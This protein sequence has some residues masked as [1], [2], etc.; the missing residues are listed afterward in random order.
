MTRTVQTSDNNP[1]LPS[2]HRAC[3]VHRSWRL[4]VL[5]LKVRQAIIHLQSNQWLR[6]GNNSDVILVTVLVNSSIFVYFLK[7]D[8]FRSVIFRV[9]KSE[10][11]FLT[12]GC[13]SGPVWH[14]FLGI[15]GLKLHKN[16]WVYL[17]LV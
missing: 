16:Q 1:T 5:Q 7:S 8:Y 13:C 6:S 17:H 14:L 11:F 10:V 9:A 2:F 12:V 4:Q 15:S 3:P